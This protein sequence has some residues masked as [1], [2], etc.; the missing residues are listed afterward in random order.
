[1][2]WDVRVKQIQV[3]KDKL[4]VLSDVYL[5]RHIVVLS[6]VLQKKKLK[7]PLLYVE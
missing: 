1:M 5:I 4:L 7:K 3:L 6:I 2:L